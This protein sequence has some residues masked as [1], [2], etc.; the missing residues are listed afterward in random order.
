[1]ISASTAAAI[2][3]LAGRL[4][5]DL[6]WR[7]ETLQLLIERRPPRRI[8]TLYLIALTKRRGVN[9]ISS[10]VEQVHGA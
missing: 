4:A 1:V 5:E 3:G 10:D 9:H 7:G 8:A 2:P 6:L